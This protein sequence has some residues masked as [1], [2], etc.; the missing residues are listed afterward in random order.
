MDILWYLMISYDIL[1]Y[2]R[3]CFG[4][5]LAFKF[6]SK[7]DF[8]TPSYS[9][10]TTS[11]YPAFFCFE[12]NRQRISETHR[13]IENGRWSVNTVFAKFSVGTED[14]PSLWRLPTNRQGWQ[15]RLGKSK[16]AASSAEDHHTWKKTISVSISYH[17]TFRK[18]RFFSEPCLK[19]PGYHDVIQSHSMDTLGL[20]L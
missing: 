2:L 20:W 11:L 14:E 15:L 1:W 18:W 19:V 4:A 16:V 6:S 3:S 8:G 7:F 10:R 13:G 9:L 5:I 17:E 12:T